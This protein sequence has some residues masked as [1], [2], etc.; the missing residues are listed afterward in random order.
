MSPESRDYWRSSKVAVIGGGAFGTVLANLAARNC[1]EVRL[2]VRDEEQ[3]RQI[4]ATRVNAKYLP[5]Y[6]LLRN[7]IAYA[8]VERIFTEGLTDGGHIAAVLWA[9]PSRVCRDSAKRLAPLFT[10]EEILIHATKGIE[11]GTMK[12]VSELLREELPCP[13]IGVLSGPNLATELAK[14][15]PAATTIASVFAE[16]IEAGEA[17]FASELFRIY[18]GNDVIGVEWAGTLKNVLAIAAGAVDALGF[19]WNARAMLITRGLAEMV[20]FGVAM[21]AQESTFLSLAGVGD[22]MATCASPLSRNYRVGFRLAKGEPL[23][24]ILKELGSTAEGVATTRSVQEYAEARGIVMPITSAVHELL[25]Q[26]RPIQE[27]L[28]DLMT[29]PSVGRGG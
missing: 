4:N 13:R 15:Q 27:L 7:V 14:G 28:R 2:W 26:K 24:A 12:R 8:D 16:V 19:G 21:G 23:D 6:D 25:G 5:E 9:L 18:R 10:G 11:P 3:A 22:L 20:R 29:R 1:Q 17:V